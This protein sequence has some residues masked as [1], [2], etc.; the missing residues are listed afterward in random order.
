MSKKIL[1]DCENCGRSFENEKQASIHEKKCN[2][3]KLPKILGWASIIL[4]VII[5]II[6]II[7]GSIGKVKAKNLI[8]KQLNKIGIIVS[9]LMWIFWGIIKIVYG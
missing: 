5:P 6:G 8:D 1:F 7:L 2:T 4:G 9:I 3:S